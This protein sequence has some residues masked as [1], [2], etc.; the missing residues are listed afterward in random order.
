M[1]AF[2][3]TSLPPIVRLGDSADV[4]ASVRRDTPAALVPRVVRRQILLPEL[5]EVK[6][7]KRQGKVVRVRG[8]SKQR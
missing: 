4:A 1:T 7:L 2:S 5:T 6:P 3:R 8:R